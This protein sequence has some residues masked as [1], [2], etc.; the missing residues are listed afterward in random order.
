M[1]RVKYLFAGMDSGGG[2]VFLRGDVAPRTNGHSRDLQRQHGCVFEYIHGWKGE[3]E[4]GLEGGG[5][6]GGVRGR[7]RERGG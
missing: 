5:G 7:E 6:R 1:D 3:G 4:G 2:G